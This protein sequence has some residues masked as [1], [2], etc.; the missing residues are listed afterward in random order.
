[1]I[2]ITIDSK[3][4]KSIFVF[5]LSVLL[6]NIRKHLLKGCEQCR[7]SS[8]SICLNLLTG[9]SPAGAFLKPYITKTPYA[10]GEG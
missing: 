3:V 2:I 8:K 9:I 7:L 6:E 4:S 10:K 5:K 1:M